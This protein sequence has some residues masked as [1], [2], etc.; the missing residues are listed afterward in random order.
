MENIIVTIKYINAVKCAP[1]FIVRTD[2]KQNIELEVQTLYCHWK[3]ALDKK[4]VNSTN[5]NSIDANKLETYE[6][7]S[8]GQY[9]SIV[10][11]NNESVKWSVGKT[12]RS[13][14][15]HT[16]AI[17]ISIT[18]ITMSTKVMVALKVISDLFGLRF[19]SRL[20]LQLLNPLEK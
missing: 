20:T 19:L 1:N 3:Q 4:D 8:N 2:I 17:S 11:L 18:H 12:A 6:E 14:R 13:W 16:K 7:R 5:L 15:L 10:L 9:W